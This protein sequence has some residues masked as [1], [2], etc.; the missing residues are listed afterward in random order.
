MKT[1]LLRQDMYF[2]RRWIMTVS[3]QIAELIRH[4][5]NAQLDD[6]AWSIC[7]RLRWI[8]PRINQLAEPCSNIKRRSGSLQ[9]NGLEYVRSGQYFQVLN[10]SRKIAAAGQHYLNDPYDADA[11]FD[12]AIQLASNGLGEHADLLQEELMQID[13]ASAAKLENR[14]T[15]LQ[16]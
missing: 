15:E 4:K 10:P 7:L 13:P 5:M 3:G 9:R 12:L 8:L 2:S 14:I 1:A 11:L 16:Q 6:E